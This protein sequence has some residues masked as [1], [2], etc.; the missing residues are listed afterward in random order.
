M[1]IALDADV[2]IF[3]TTPTPWTADVRATI[4]DADLFGSVL[5]PVEVLAKPR[6]LGA[7]SELAA[8]EALLAHV[9][10]LPVT[11]ATAVL[12]TE[13][14]AAHRLPSMDAVHLATAIEA[15]ADVFLTNN[16]K[17]FGGITVDGPAIVS[18]HD[19][20]APT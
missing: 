18:P 15:R 3:A 16:T 2:C 13:L 19:R 5:L 9:R 17:D 6:R 4:A 10:L 8:L 20:Q 12:A 11:A 7:T 1:R 14:A